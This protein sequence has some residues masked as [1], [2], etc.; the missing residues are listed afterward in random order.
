[1]S[2]AKGRFYRKTGRSSVLGFIRI[3]LVVVLIHV[4]DMQRVY[5][6]GMRSQVGKNIKLI[7]SYYLDRRVSGSISKLANH[8]YVLFMKLSWK[9]ISFHSG[10]STLEE[11]IFAFE[12]KMYQ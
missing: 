4:I 2:L 1:M 6:L 8:S 10:L 5:L 9:S 11:I 3:R 12:G 7:M